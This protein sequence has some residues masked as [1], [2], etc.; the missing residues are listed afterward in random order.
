MTLM[1]TPKLLA[2]SLLRAYKALISPQLP[3]SCRFTPTCSEY[4]MEAVER[5]G[6]VV[7]SLL[8]MW[9]IL[10]CNPL[11]HGGLDTVPSALAFQ[12]ETRNQK[13]ET[14]FRKT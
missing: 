4:A 3:Q 1:Q 2:Q 13:L 10:R 14:A 8:S 11:S 6:V 7:G 9:R 12:R 5:H